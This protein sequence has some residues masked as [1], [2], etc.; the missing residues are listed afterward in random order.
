MTQ[1]GIGLGRDPAGGGGGVGAAAPGG[2]PEQWRRP[3]YEQRGAVDWTKPEYATPHPDRKHKYGRYV[4]PVLDI[5]QLPERLIRV[6]SKFPASYYTLEG[7]PIPADT[8]V[9]LPISP[10]LIQ[11]V[12]DGTL[13]RGQ[14]PVDEPR[15][16]Q[17]RPQRP[18]RPPAAE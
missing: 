18:P 3:A 17:T 15:A 11:A 14:D 12:K 5:P 10:G 1:I 8:W 9:T 2:Q 7:V 16:P 13:E 6:R 4:Q